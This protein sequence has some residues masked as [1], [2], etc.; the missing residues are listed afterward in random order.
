MITLLFYSEY[1]G[2]RYYEM[3]LY[4]E[5]FCV[6]YSGIIVVLEVFGDLVLLL[7]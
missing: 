4:S 6:H 3:L 7:L 2:V 5:Y 1:F